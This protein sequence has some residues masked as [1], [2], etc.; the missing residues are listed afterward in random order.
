MIQRLKHWETKKIKATERRRKKKKTLKIL[1]AYAI[2]QFICTKNHTIRK[3]KTTLEIFEWKTRKANKI[4]EK[5]EELKLNEKKT[6]THTKYNSTSFQLLRLIVFDIQNAECAS[7]D[8]NSMAFYSLLGLLLWET[9]PTERGKNKN[10]KIAFSC[11][12]TNT[13]IVL[14]CNWYR[15][16]CWKN[17]SWKTYS[18]KRKFWHSYQCNRIGI[19]RLKVSTIHPD[20]H[21]CHY[22]TSI[23]IPFYAKQLFLSF[24]F[25]LSLSVLDNVWC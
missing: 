7:I 12:K 5:Y 1:L 25:F 2:W 24:I 19:N 21:A 14:T 16:S 22:A 3:T 10:K 20:F 13:A 6:H 18:R 4:N 11:G 17:Y 9:R 15:C 8:T 23:G